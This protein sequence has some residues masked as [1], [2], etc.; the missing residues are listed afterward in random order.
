M[1]AGEVGVGGRD[2]R[3]SRPITTRVALVHAVQSLG[4]ATLVG[5]RLAT[6]FRRMDDMQSRR[7]G[8]PPDNGR[9]RPV[10]RNCLVRVQVFVDSDSTE[11]SDR[12]SVPAGRASQA[13][14]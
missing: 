4:T 1:C 5:V 10:R 8:Q 14:Q 6:G 2:V 9:L 13:T 11:G 3:Y 12:R 7:I